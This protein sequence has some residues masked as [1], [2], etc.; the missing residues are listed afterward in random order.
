MAAVTR[1][2]TTCSMPYGTTDENSAT[3]T[4]APASRTSTTTV[5]RE[6]AKNGAK[7]SVPAVIATD[8]G[9]TPVPW[10]A[11]RRPSTMYPAQSTAATPMASSPRR[12]SW[13]PSRKVTP[14]SR[15]TPHAAS[16]IPALS[17]QPRPVTAATATGPMNSIATAVPSGSRAMAR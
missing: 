12:T 3:A 5:P 6:R 1:L 9:P 2:R 17:R 11:T 8:S 10:C 15:T 7:A 13:P 16:P 14:V 4:T